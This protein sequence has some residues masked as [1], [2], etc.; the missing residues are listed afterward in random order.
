[1]G[2]CAFIALESPF[3]MG[4]L[5]LAAVLFVTSIVGG[6]IGLGRTR[7]G[8]AAGRSGRRAHLAY[9]TLAGINGAIFFV[10]A[11]GT[12]A[13]YVWPFGPV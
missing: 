2:L 7:L 11:Q 9:A 13:C 3:H 8:I 6:I 12:A 5:T 4:A 1:M 10:V